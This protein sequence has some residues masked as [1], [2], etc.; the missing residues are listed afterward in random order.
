M[1]T[2]YK[3]SWGRE[4]IE[5]IDVLRETKTSVFIESKNWSNTFEEKRVAK[6]S[7]FE[8][9]FDSWPEAH[10]FCM[11]AAEDKV[12]S[13]RRALEM[14]NAKLGNIKGMKESQP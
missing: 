9:Y 13:A 7:Q 4:R 14:A 11:K 12:M 6:M 1:I 5:K 2:K 3:A 10:A 8:C